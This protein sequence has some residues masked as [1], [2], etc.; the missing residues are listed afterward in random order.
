MQRKVF[1]IYIKKEMFL[2]SNELLG[3]CIPSFVQQSASGIFT[4]ANNCKI[5]VTPRTISLSS[6]YL[7]CK[8]ALALSKRTHLI[9][10]WY[11]LRKQENV[12]KT[13]PL[14]LA[15]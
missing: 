3:R 12:K 8:R 1:F 13:A 9:Y 10:Q 5:K 14:L 7:F 6:M 15:L 11:T 4:G 2:P